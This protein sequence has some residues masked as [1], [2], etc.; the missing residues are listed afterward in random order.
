MAE[1]RQVR[2]PVNVERVLH[3]G[4]SA[5]DA[6]QGTTLSSTGVDSPFEQAPDDRHRV[7]RLRQVESEADADLEAGGVSFGG[8]A[9]L[10]LV[11]GIR[12]QAGIFLD[13]RALGVAERLLLLLV[14]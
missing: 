10:R 9:K 7:Q 13:N 2:Q 1:T 5:L 3:D 6:K 8:A 11:K 14:E 4:V 12:H